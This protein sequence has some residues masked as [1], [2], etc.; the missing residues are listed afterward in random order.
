MMLGRFAGRAPKDGAAAA[1]KAPRNSLRFMLKILHRAGSVGPVCPSGGR[2]TIAALPCPQHGRATAFVWFWAA[3]AGTRLNHAAGFWLL[4]QQLAPRLPGFRVAG[5][6][7]KPADTVG[8]AAYVSKFYLPRSG[9]IYSTPIR[10]KC[11]PSPKSLS[12]YFHT[13]KN[14][15]TAS[16][17]TG[18]A[19][20]SLLKYDWC[21][22]TVS[23]ASTCVALRMFFGT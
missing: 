20:G 14:P 7:H 11:S 1:P 5:C 3:A 2:A 4:M 15:K 21:V 10:F 16:R 22:S 13:R 9:G 23:T 18:D 17:A 19:S 12:A 8:R 6:P